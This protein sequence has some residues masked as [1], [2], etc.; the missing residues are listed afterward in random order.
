MRQMRGD[1]LKERALPRGFANLTGPRLLQVSDATMEQ[2]GRCRRGRAAK[3]I[4]LHQRDGKSAERCIV[5]TARTG[6]ATANDDDIERRV[7]EH[8]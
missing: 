6:D 4:T 5:G 1:P 7:G 2:L 8:R 3:V